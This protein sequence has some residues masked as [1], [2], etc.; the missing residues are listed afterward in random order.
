MNRAPTRIPA[1]NI[2]RTQTFPWKNV[3]AMGEM[4]LLGVPPPSPKSTEA[5][6]A[7]Y[8]SYILVVEELAR[9]N[10]SHAFGTEAQKRRS[11]WDPAT[12]VDLGKPGLSGSAPAIV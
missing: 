11:Q 3:R 1:G 4:G 9:H 6:D 8:L 5:W 7:D 10:A 12:V 2:D